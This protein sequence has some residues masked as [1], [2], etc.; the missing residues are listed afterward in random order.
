[1]NVFLDDSQSKAILRL[2]DGASSQYET[3]MQ[4]NWQKHSSLITGKLNRTMGFLLTAK[5][6]I[7]T[8]KILA[9]LLPFM[10]GSDKTVHVSANI[11]KEYAEKFRTE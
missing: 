11:A 7:F 4:Y 5:Q 10:V 9:Y 2:L 3:K 8:C 6:C 1:M